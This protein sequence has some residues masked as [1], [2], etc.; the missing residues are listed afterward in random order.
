MSF[1]TRMFQIGV[2]RVQLFATILCQATGATP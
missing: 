1:N 2:Q